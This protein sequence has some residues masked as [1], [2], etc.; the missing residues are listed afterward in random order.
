MIELPTFDEMVKMAKEQ[1]DQLNDLQMEVN[2][3]CINLAPE[4]TRPAL[5]STL[6]HIKQI[7]LSASNPYERCVLMNRAM[8]EK[9]S[10]LH[11]ALTNP[12]LLGKT[13]NVTEVDFRNRRA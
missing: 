8:H 1:P 10:L 3:Q 2:R 5:E 7:Q 12:E 9:L 4:E 11:T 6:H 13:D